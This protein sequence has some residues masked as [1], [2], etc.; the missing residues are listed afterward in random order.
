MFAGIDIVASKLDRFIGAELEP[1][2]NLTT[3]LLAGA[4][5]T[6][7]RPLQ[8]YDRLHRL[9]LRDHGRSDGRGATVCLD[10]QGSNHPRD[11]LSIA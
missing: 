4:S 8:R 3:Q 7:K 5:P 2:Q 6:A 11:G 10:S 9:T 1:R